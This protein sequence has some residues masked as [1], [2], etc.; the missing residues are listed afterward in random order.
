MGSD[1]A[2]GELYLPDV[3]QVIRSRD[4]A[5]LAFEVEDPLET[6]GVNDRRE[7]AEVRRI[8]QARIHEGHMLAGVTIVDPAAT[9]ID[10][11]VEIATDAV[12][13]PFSSLRGRTRVGAQA[14]I[15]P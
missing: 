11:A 13:E 3:L 1:N 6:L 10:A 4:R 8:A 12:I 5:V 2:Q 9:V 7:L 15:G 14:V